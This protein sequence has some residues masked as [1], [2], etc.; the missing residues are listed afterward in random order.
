MK[1]IRMQYVK[2]GYFEIQQNIKNGRDTGGLREELTSLLQS[3]ELEKL[4][5]QANT[6]YGEI[7]LINNWFGGHMLFFG[8]KTNRVVKFFQKSRKNFRLR[9][10]GY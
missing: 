10:A 6:L 3:F 9:R 1:Y 4:T 5:L 2:S 7:M 8:K